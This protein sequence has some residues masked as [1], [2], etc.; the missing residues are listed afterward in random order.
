MSIILKSRNLILS[1][2]RSDWQV[3]L[4]MVHSGILMPAD[5][6]SKESQKEEVWSAT[7]HLSLKRPSR[8]LFCFILQSFQS[9]DRWLLLSKMAFV[10]IAQFLGSM[11]PQG[12]ACYV[13][14]MVAS[15]I[16]TSR[17]QTAAWIRCRENPSELIIPW[18]SL[19]SSSSVS[20]RF[21][22]GQLLLHCT[23]PRIL[24]RHGWVLW[25]L[26]EIG[27]KHSRLPPGMIHSSHTKEEG[28]LACSGSKFGDCLSALIHTL[29]AQS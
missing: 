11:W 18:G 19:R 23:A 16:Y 21:C 13:F 2:A 9:I 15:L 29:R 5:R 3:W 12:A 20:L 4:F 8:I 22:A 1:L 28:F 17:C 25:A 27:D 10:L 14:L 24:G 26:G 7:V 6:H